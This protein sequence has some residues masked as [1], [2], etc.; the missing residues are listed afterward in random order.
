MTKA[1]EG[2]S[3]GAA[4]ETLSAATGFLSSRWKVALLATAV[5]SIVV[6]IM[7]PPMIR[8][9]KGKPELA[10]AVFWGSVAGIMT[11]VLPWVLFGRQKKEESGASV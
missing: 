8:D 3:G 1:Q 5:G 7:S 4:A 10:K 6:F 9:D 11:F 2:I